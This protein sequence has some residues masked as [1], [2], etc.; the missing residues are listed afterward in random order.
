MLQVVC[1]ILLIACYVAIFKLLAY[2]EPDE[3]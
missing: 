3:S 2:R 1:W